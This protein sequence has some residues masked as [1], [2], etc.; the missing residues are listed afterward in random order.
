MPV[1]AEYAQEGPFKLLVGERIA[2][3]IDGTVEI[4]EP[5]GDVVDDGFDAR[6]TESHDHR[7]DVPG[8]P[9]ENKRSEDDG[10]GPQSLACPVLVLA[11]L[12]CRRRRRSGSDRRLTAAT[13]PPSTA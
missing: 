3:R 11:R 9:A 2:E 1:A 13:T 8:R 6:Q 5:V 10:D 4:T 7:E 12:R